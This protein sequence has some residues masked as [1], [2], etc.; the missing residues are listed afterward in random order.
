M[1]AVEHRFGLAFYGSGANDSPAERGHCLEISWI[2]L[3]EGAPESG[4]APPSFYIHGLCSRP[5]LDVEERGT[6]TRL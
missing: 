6:L 2:S 5:S 1:D 3:M 4:L